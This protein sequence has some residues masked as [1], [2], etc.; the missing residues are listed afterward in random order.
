VCA[1]SS[2]NIRCNADSRTVRLLDLYEP[3]LTVRHTSYAVGNAYLRN[4]AELVGKTTQRPHTFAE[5][6]LY[7]FF[8]HDKK[9]YYKIFCISRLASNFVVCMMAVQTVK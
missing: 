2:E 5:V 4:A 1:I 6:P 8:S 9:G 3:S 7:F